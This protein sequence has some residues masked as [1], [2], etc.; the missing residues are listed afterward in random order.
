MPVIYCLKTGLCLIHNEWKNEN[1][2]NS[3]RQYYLNICNVIGEIAL[4]E[5]GWLLAIFLGSS[6]S[7]TYKDE[8]IRP[9]SFLWQSRNASMTLMSQIKHV[10]LKVK[11]FLS[12]K[13]DVSCKWMQLQNWFQIASYCCFHPKKMLSH[14]ADRGLNF[15]KK[16]FF[17][18]EG[19]SVS[20]WLEFVI[21]WWLIQAGCL[22]MTSS[23]FMIQN[24]F[25]LGGK[26]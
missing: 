2:T 17:K 4:V 24:L 5:V 20:F 6:K 1:G 11:T 14:S 16:Q 23:H 15:L 10:Q 19:T 12:Q 25:C 21:C 3:N 9:I 8:C 18:I 13:A 26:G 22:W 7:V